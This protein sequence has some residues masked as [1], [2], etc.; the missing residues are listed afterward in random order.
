[1]QNLPYHDYHDWLQ[2]PGFNTNARCPSWA[3]MQYQCPGTNKRDSIRLKLWPKTS[4]NK[5]K[6]A[7]GDRCQLLSTATPTLYWTHFRELCTTSRPEGPIACLGLGSRWPPNG[8]QFSQPLDYLPHGGIYWCQRS[9]ATRVVTSP[10]RLRQWKHGRRLIDGMDHLNSLGFLLLCTYQISFSLV[11][12]YL[13]ILFGFGKLVQK[14]WLLARIPMNLLLRFQIQRW[15]S[16]Q[17]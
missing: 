9:Q 5:N 7:L 14:Y 13:N 1:M 10:H 17:K 3:T 11:L 6:T 15:L 2:Y 16:L 12:S 4:N 8:R